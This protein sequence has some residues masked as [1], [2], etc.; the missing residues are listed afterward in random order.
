MSKVTG[1]VTVMAIG[2]ALLL[3]SVAAAAETYRWV[4]ADGNA[5]YGDRPVQGAREVDIRVPGKAPEPAS[6][7]VADTGGDSGAP[8]SA[9]PPATDEATQVRSQ[10]C[11]QAKERL[12]RYEKADGIYE[13]GTDGQRRELTLEERVD[14]ILKARQSVKDLCESPPPI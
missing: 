6:T 7:P 2:A 8:G 3:V 1:K 5:H 4:D 13:E 11:E 9:E 14:T 12:A 10:L